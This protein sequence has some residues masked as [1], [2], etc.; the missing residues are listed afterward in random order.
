MKTTQETEGKA[1]IEQTGNGTGV[2]AV[3]TEQCTSAEGVTITAIA[4]LPGDALLDVKALAWILGRCSKSVERSVRRGEFPPGFRLGR[5]H[6]WQVKKIREHLD[7]LQDKA[8]R[9][10]T[11]RAEK[12]SENPA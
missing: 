3:A 1:L 8:V 2:E 11:R 10:A 6:V 9:E 5:K 12:N 4:T 7:K